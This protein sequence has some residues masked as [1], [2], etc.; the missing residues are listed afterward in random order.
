M[1]HSTAIVSAA[2][3]IGNNVRV[4]PYSVIGD[5]VCIADNV[6]IMSHVCIDGL[7]TIG[8][9][10]KI[11]PFTTIGYVPQDLKFHGEQSQTIIGKYNTIREHVTIHAGTESGIMKTVVGDHNLLMVGVHI[12]HDCVVGN[13]VI[14]ANNVTLGGHV[15]IE[16]YVVLGGLSAVHQWVRVGQH[17]VV[18]G[19]SGVERDVI[20]FGAVKGERAHLYGL[21]LIGLRRTDMSKDEIHAL[22]K[23]YRIIFEGEHN[24]LDNV[25]LAE[26]ELGNCESVNAMLRFIKSDTGRS[27]CMPKA[28]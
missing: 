26:Q 8:E 7:T 12:A 21:N 22:Q 24:V 1:I 10:T 20:P 18:G 17:A 9:G 15:Q 3:K 28:G 5:N 11:F 19:M 6:E 16:D 4:G 23:A 14:M 25:S 2:A 13:H 27:L